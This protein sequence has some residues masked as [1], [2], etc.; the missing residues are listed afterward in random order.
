MGAGRGAER[1]VRSRR[2]V[3]RAGAATRLRTDRAASPRARAKFFDR[4]GG[5]LAAR[6]KPDGTLRAIAAVTDPRR[7]PATGGARRCSKAWRAASAARGD[8]RK[9]GDSQD[10]AADAGDRRSGARA[11]RRG[12]AAR[13]E[14]YRAR[15]GDDGR[16]SRRPRAPPPTAATPADARVDAITLL[17]LIDAPAHQPLFESVIATARARGRADC[18]RQRPGT[19]SGQQARRRSCS[20]SGRR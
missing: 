15:R 7:P 17:A 5:V 10:D 14:R 12:D 16:A 11:S 8:R 20:R 1:L 13:R 2:R 9:L 18:R 4:L 19:H 6:Q 3:F